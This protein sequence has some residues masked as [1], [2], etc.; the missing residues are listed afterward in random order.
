MST[1]IS[2]ADDVLREA[3][4]R[5][6]HFPAGFGGFSADVAWTTPD[7]SGSGSIEARL[8]DE[9]AVATS[10]LD[11][12]ADRQLR[13]MVAHRSARSYED[14]DG[15]TPKSVTEEAHGS[16]VALEDDLDS[17]YLVA[18]GQIETV[19]RTAHG[20]RF[21]IVVQGRTPAN[22]G[23]S[24]PTTFTVCYWD[25]D[26]GLTAAEAYTDTYT[27]LDGVLVP[28]SRTVVRADDTGL[29]TRR[30]TLAGHAALTGAGS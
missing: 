15:A 17:S 14:G 23:T 12:W 30:V 3:H 11:D 13:S 21:T 6:Y 1:T 10:N 19:T 28:A 27:D 9:P 8:G 2:R 16:R 29:S 18:G 20:T 4:D 25:T 22:D 26:G 7:G 5:G 24:V